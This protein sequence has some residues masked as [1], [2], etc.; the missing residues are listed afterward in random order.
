VLAH[1]VAYAEAHG[2]SLDD[3]KGVEIRHKCDNPA[4]VEPTHLIAGTH[5]QNMRDMKNR[6]RVGRT[7]KLTAAQVLDIRKQR[8]AG[9]LFRELQAQY[10]ISSAQLHRI[11]TGKRWN[12]PLYLLGGGPS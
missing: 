1:R 11:T 10:G 2:L 9:V 12:N 5:A 4:C 8:A 7:C 3:I 6:G